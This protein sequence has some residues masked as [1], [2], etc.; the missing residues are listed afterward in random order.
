MSPFSELYFQLDKDESGSVSA[1]DLTSLF[2]SIDSNKNDQITAREFNSAIDSIL[3]ETCFESAKLW[4]DCADSPDS[5]TCL[6]K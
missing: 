6:L 1:A 5:K 4:G 3:L 2:Q